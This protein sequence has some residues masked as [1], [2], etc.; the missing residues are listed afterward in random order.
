MTPVSNKVRMLRF[1]NS[2]I[3]C[4]TLYSAVLS[5]IN[6]KLPNAM[7]C[8]N[9][10]KVPIRSSSSPRTEN[11]TNVGETLLFENKNGTYFPQPTILLVFQVLSEFDAVALEALLRRL[12][13]TRLLLLL[14][15]VGGVVV[16]AHAHLHLPQ[17]LGAARRRVRVLQPEEMIRNTLVDDEH[18]EVGVEGTGLG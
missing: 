7:V 17:R 8:V 11:M 5:T 10:E 13:L 1:L 14:E 16:V 6:F 3:L 18:F 9:S 4:V 2:Y 15:G 12:L